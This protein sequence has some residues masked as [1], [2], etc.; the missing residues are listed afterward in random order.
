M[1]IVKNTGPLVHM[2]C[3]R[4]K[5]TMQTGYVVMRVEFELDENAPAETTAFCLVCHEKQFTYISLTK[6]VKQL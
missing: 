2:D 6:I 3:S 1:N 5:E 4:Q